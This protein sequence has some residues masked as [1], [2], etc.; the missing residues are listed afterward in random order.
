MGYV[1][2]LMIF[3]TSVNRFSMIFWRI[4]YERTWNKYF[5]LILL[6]VVLF[7]I[8]FTWTV[9]TGEAY[10]VYIPSLDNF[11]VTST[12]NRD[13]VYNQLVLFFAFITIM[14]A[15]INIASFYY[16]SC[17]TSKISIAERNLLF[18]SGSLFLIQLIADVN[19]TLSR[20][21]KNQDMVLSQIATTLLPYISDG[22]TFIHPWLLLLC[23]SRARTRFLKMYIP[24]YSKLEKRTNSISIFL[25]TTT[26]RKSLQSR[27]LF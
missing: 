19:T 23:S 5:Y 11:K 18:M 2:F 16:L 17:I 3:L 20:L 24:G 13:L 4:T 8:P 7:P 1:Q 9:L 22:L 10:Y 14:T 6:C 25:P 21:D 12:M 27:N 26:S 15:I